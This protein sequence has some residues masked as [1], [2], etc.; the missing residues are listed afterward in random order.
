MTPVKSGHIEWKIKDRKYHEDNNVVKSYDSVITKKYQ[1]EHKYFTIDKW[2][3]DLKL[4]K[5]SLVLDFGCGTGTST[6]KLLKN[7]IT[8][9][10][11]DASLQMVQLLKEKCKEE[12]LN[13]LCVV[14]DVENLPFKDG[15]F[16]GLVCAGVLHH[17]PDIN[18]GVKNQI[19]VMKNRA[20]LF[21]AEP[22]SYK[23]WFSYPYYFAVRA[24]NLMLDIIKKHAVQS[25]E[26]LL[27]KSD[28]ENI[29]SILEKGG[30]E[31]S[32]S[33]FVY[34]PMLCKCLPESISYPIIRFLNRINGNSQK[35]DTFV[36]RAMKK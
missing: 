12:K 30:F 36:I 15:I 11:T 33:S 28:L 5:K 8:T 22:F 31:C 16:D 19:R 21:I 24:V 14:S 13:C 32:A 34:W 17:V 10:S 25:R 3:K 20:I 23:P 1:L 18:K 29:M 27:S 4:A 7:G 35:G 9:V 26:R 6:I 2:A